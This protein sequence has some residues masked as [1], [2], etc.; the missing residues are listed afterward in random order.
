MNLNQWDIMQVR[1]PGSAMDRSKPD[2]HGG[3]D[4]EHRHH[5]GAGVLL[6]HGHGDGSLVDHLLRRARALHLS[7]PG[8]H[9]REAGAPHQDQ[10]SPGGAV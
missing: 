3:A 10:Q 1:D 5:P 2:H 8:R 6:P 4:G 7:D 9:R